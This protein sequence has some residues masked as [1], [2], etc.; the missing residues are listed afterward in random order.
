MASSASGGLFP[1]P[2]QDGRPEGHPQ[3]EWSLGQKESCLCLWNRVGRV[4]WLWVERAW[5]NPDLTQILIPT[6]GLRSGGF[7]SWKTG[8]T[9]LWEGSQAPEPEEAG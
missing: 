8:V 3:R 5:Q 1:Y 9:E 7:H 6:G 2:G 4:W